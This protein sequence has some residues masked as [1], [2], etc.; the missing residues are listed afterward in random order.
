MPVMSIAGHL[1]GSHT[2]PPFANGDRKVKCKGLKGTD[3]QWSVKLLW[4]KFSQP[5]AS[6]TL[7]GGYNENRSVGS[8]QYT[9]ADTAYQELIHCA[10]SVGSDD[11]CIN[12]QIRG[13]RQNRVNRLAVNK[14]GGCIYP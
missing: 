11:N 8:A 4:S 13:F 14:K 2:E 9:F 10:M 7:V 12:V 3:G 6:V 5:G 1:V